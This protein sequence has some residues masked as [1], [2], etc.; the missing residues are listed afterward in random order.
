M[1]VFYKGRARRVFLPGM[2]HKITVGMF[3]EDMARRAFCQEFSIRIIMGV[4]TKTLLCV[5]SVRL[6]RLESQWTCFV[7]K[8]L[9]M[10]SAKYAP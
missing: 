8:W 6:V 2:S 4:F 1:G 9:G 10:F 3:Y 7:R 5:F